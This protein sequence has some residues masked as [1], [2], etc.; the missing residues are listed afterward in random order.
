[1]YLIVVFAICMHLVWGI[2]IL[3]NPAIVGVTGIHTLSY[4][5]DDATILGAI[6]IV[7]AGLATIGI[8]Q[9]SL[10]AFVLLL[11]QQAVLFISSW[12]ALVAMVTGQ[13]AD[14][15]ARPH[16]FLITDQCHLL[17]CATLHFIAAM[18]KAFQD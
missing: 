11:P 12:G 10:F 2:C 16:T 5:V 4:I 15:V 8:M 3:I 1:M 17:I 9:K 13:F 7:V 14:G 6:L 18:R